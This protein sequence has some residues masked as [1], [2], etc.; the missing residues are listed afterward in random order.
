MLRD[1]S[2]HLQVG[3]LL[4]DL[5]IALNYSVARYLVQHP[6]AYQARA[7]CSEQQQQ[8]SWQV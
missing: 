4:I 7:Q 8:S 5:S 6:H 3:D 1:N 2:P